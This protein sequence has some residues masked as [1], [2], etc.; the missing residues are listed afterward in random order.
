MVTHDSRAERHVDEIFRLEKGV[1]MGIE[2]G[3]GATQ[4]RIANVAST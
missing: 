4:A 1:L 3:Q 2:T